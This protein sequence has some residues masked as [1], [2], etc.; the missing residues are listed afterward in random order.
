MRHLV[1]TILA[2]SIAGVAAIAA[3]TALLNTPL[4]VTPAQGGASGNAPALTQA[5]PTPAS[6]AEIPDAPPPKDASAAEASA[7]A[8]APAG[9]TPAADG[10]V[11]E[12]ADQDPYE[13]IAPEDLPPDL[14]YDADASVSFPT[15]T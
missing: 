5:E 3:T 14:Q 2:I 4:R 15:N 8:P 1:G 12:E 6:S 7:P 9:G 13:G 11:A 10:E